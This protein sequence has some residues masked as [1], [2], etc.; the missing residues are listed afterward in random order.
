[1]NFDLVSWMK[2]EP[3]QM[4]SKKAYKVLYPSINFE[5][6]YHK[7]IQIYSISYKGQVF[8]TASGHEESLWE[9]Q[10]LLKQILPL[11]LLWSKTHKPWQQSHSYCSSW[12][13]KLRDSLGSTLNTLQINNKICILET[14][15]YCFYQKWSLLAQRQASW[16]SFVCPHGGNT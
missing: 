14:T 4:L 15:K 12:K 9:I 6:T 11:N 7:C 10:H 13:G 8:P 2:Q 16:C 5:A 3:L 1:M